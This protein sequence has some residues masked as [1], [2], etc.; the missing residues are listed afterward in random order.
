MGGC[1]FFVVLTENQLIKYTFFKEDLRTKKFQDEP[2]QFIPR[3]QELIGQ[4][5]GANEKLVSIF[6]DMKN[7]VKMIY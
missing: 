6:A 5:N 7:E 3:L 1:P 2:K 4:M